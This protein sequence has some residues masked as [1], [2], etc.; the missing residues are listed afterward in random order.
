MSTQQLH[1]VD[2]IIDSVIKQDVHKKRFIFNKLENKIIELIN[3]INDFVD[4]IDKLFNP[5]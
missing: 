2:E 1:N 5:Y 4:K 3:I